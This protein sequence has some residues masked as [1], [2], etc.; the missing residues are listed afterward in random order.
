[1]DSKQD[2]PETPNL[3]QPLARILLLVLFLIVAGAAIIIS[4]SSGVKTKDK[5]TDA[6]KIMKEEDDFAPP[7]DRNQKPIAL[8]PELAGQI[9]E[10]DG[11]GRSIVEQAPYRELMSQLY[12]RTSDFLRYALGFQEAD[13]DSILR[14]PKAF[15]GRTL[16]VRGVL[17]DVAVRILEQPIGDYQL[18][19]YGVIKDNQNRLFWFETLQFDEENIKDVGEWV[20]A[21][22]V[23]FKIF[24]YFRVEKT[25]PYYLK[26]LPEQKDNLPMLVCRSVRRSY[27]IEEVTHFDKELVRS[28]AWKTESDQRVLEP[29]PFYHLMGYMKNLKNDQIPTNIKTYEDMTHRLLK[30]SQLDQYRG[31]WVSIWG[32]LGPIYKYA[33]EENPAGIKHHYRAYLKTSDQCMVEVILLEKPVG[34]KPY[35]DF[36]RV[37]GIYFKNRIWDSDGGKPVRAP[38]IVARNLT[39]ITFGRNIW[40]YVAFGLAISLTLA[41]LF[42]SFVVY[43]ERRAIKKHNEEFIRR[44]RERRLRTGSRLET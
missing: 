2:Y 44:R 14:D 41:V 17:V 35:E 40:S 25:S 15:R 36:V 33:P 37:R 29:H 43:N 27:K 5:P 4:Y 19:H 34:F 32:K 18:V 39:R 42:I 10:K 23:F 8:S 16:F 31:E 9:N 20:I 26:D 7:V 3:N 11:V 38:V 1:M 22:G 28:A 6:D 13:Y 12:N 21:E 30:P 24:K